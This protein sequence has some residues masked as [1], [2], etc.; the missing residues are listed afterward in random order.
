MFDAAVKT[1]AGSLFTD[2]AV[3]ERTEDDDD[4]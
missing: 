1:A 3:R 2:D 4:G